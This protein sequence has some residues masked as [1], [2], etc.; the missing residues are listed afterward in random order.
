M[1]AYYQNYKD[2]KMP[3]DSTMR[4][5]L[6]IVAIDADNELA[7]GNLADAYL[8][9]GDTAKAIEMDLKLYRLNP[10]NLS[11]A[12]TIVQMLAG[13]G[14]PAQAL[15]IAKE[16]LNSN[17][18]DAQIL[19]T[20]WKLLQATKQWKQAIAT[21][22]EMVKFDSSKADTNYFNRQMSAAIADSQPQLLLQYLG[23]ATAKFPKNTRYWLGYSQELRKAGQL[24]QSLDAAKKALAID[25]SLDNG[26]PTVLSLYIALGQADSALAFGKLALANKADKAQVGGALLTL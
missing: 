19:E 2:K 22:E 6:E 14:A 10:T 17:P 16:L 8:L 25:P 3:I 12:Q 21:G 7:I 24:Q 18:G 9:K 15:P 26:Y 20:Y 5:A 23:K 1:S 13:S 11:Q 4:V